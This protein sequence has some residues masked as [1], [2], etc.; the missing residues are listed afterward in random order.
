MKQLL[1]T[2]PVHRRPMGV[3]VF[4]KHYN[5]PEEVPGGILHAPGLGLDVVAVNAQL[6]LWYGKLGDAVTDHQR[7]IA[8]GVIHALEMVRIIHGL[9]PVPLSEETC[10]M[11]GGPS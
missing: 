8:D 6:Q 2:T 10:L 11:K 9:P 4:D 5:S 3:T 7:S 1:A